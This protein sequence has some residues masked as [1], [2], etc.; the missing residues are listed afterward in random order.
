MME[1]EIGQEQ[2]AQLAALL[3]EGNG[4][5]ATTDPIDPW[6]PPS[7]GTPGSGTTSDP[8]AQDPIDPWSP[9]EAP[10]N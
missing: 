7:D 10:A 4:T 9:E 8:K 6:S 3:F 2:D 5:D 1:Q